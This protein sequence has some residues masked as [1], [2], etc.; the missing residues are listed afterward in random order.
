[1]Q[2]KVMQTIAL[3]QGSGAHQKSFDVSGL[4]AGVYL[5]TLQSGIE[6]T[7]KKLVITK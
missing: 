1:M 5:M 7:V 6:N 4:P 2:G 3:G